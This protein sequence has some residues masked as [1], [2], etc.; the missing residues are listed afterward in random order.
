MHFL[1]MLLAVLVPLCALPFSVCA[2]N[3]PLS[4][5]T[6]SVV[7]AQ[8]PKFTELDQAINNTDGQARGINP[9][10]ELV[11]MSAAIESKSYQG[12]L[13]YEFGGP[14]ETL[15]FERLMGDSGTQE[16]I[17]HLSGQPRSFSRSLPQDYCSNAATRLFMQ[18][19]SAPLQ[20]LSRYYQFSAIG[21]NRIA[22]RLVNLIQ[23]QPIND[24]RYGFTLGIDQASHLP[25]MLTVTGYRG[26][27][28]ERFQFV[29]FHLAKPN[30]HANKQIYAA[31]KL[32]F[33]QARCKTPQGL[34]GWL[35]SW[36]P[37]GFVL[38]SA[39]AQEDSTTVLS[40]TDGLASVSVF[41]TPI[42][43]VTGAVGVVKRGA[44]VA[45]MTMVAVDQQS[46][47]VSVVGEVPP[48][49][50]RRIASSMVYRP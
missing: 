8:P 13:T 23:I 5:S 17:R 47:K 32:P 12:T 18:A 40:F 28:L 44:T 25:L 37:A 4:S 16:S 1:K 26:Q 14:L 20:Y 48:A 11:L 42:A 49:V 39:N 21:Q 35:P 43:K 15:A 22:D 33:T 9:L 27:V 30:E 31:Q 3:M 36:L 19:G 24:D 7:P 2:Q 50:A 34:V 10:R 38:A 29:D 6:G 46:F 41:V 45:A